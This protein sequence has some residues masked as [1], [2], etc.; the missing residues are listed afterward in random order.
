MTHEIGHNLGMR[1]DDNSINLDL[2]S[3]DEDG[4]DHIMSSKPSKR[5]R[6]SW[7]KC[8]RRSFEALYLDRKSHWCM[9]GEA[10]LKPTEITRVYKT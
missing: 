4:N 6:K 1:G 10:I 9:T 5:E 8:S 2:P 7:S 3:C